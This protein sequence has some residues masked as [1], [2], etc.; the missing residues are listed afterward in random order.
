VTGSNLNHRRIGE[1]TTRTQNPPYDHRPASLTGTTPA[2][3]QHDEPA[4]D[5]KE[6]IVLARQRQAP[7]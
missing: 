5:H 2:R 4:L 1:V 6:E 7:D 3:P